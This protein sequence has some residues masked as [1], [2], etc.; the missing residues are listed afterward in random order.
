MLFDE[1]VGTLVD[2]LEVWGID[3]GV[4]VGR[5]VVVKTVGK[6]VGCNVGI[7]VGFVVCVGQRVIIK[8]FIKNKQNLEVEVHLL[9][10]FTKK[11]FQH[12]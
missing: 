3:E 10:F 8:F 4:E 6:T 9:L 11:N 12:L 7:L 2:L 5:A 1:F